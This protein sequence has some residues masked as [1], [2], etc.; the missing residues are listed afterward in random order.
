MNLSLLLHIL[1][2]IWSSSDQLAECKSP[3]LLQA[4]EFPRQSSVYCRLNIS[5]ALDGE[6]ENLDSPWAEKYTYAAPGTEMLTEEWKRMKYNMIYPHP[7][8]RVT[9]SFQVFC[10]HDETFRFTV[11]PARNHRG[12]SFSFF[13]PGEKLDVLQPD[14]T[15]MAF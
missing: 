6:T 3:H 14:T 4:A 15:R 8:F 1:R 5:F 2:M 12:R 13:T 10:L 11:C 7:R 9:Q